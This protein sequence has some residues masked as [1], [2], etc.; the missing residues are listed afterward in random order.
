M[1][2]INFQDLP[3]KDTPIDSTNLNLLQTNVENS[4]NEISEKSEWITLSSDYQCF[5]RKVGKVVE[6]N[7]IASSK[8]LEFGKNIVLGTLNEGFRPSKR[9]RSFVY[10]RSNSV[11]T[12]RNIYIEIQPTGNVYMFNWDKTDT[13]EALSSIITY[14]I[15]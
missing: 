2:K 9:I 15:D 13:F 3:S 14:T 10:N 5:Y 1:E 4:I 11:A 6:L 7:M 12:P 8:S